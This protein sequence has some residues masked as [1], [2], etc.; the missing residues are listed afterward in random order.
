MAGVWI[1]GAAE[2]IQTERE[3]QY[4]SGEDSIVKPFVILG[5]SSNIARMMKGMDGICL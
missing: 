4:E 1:C 2:S 3:N 5:F